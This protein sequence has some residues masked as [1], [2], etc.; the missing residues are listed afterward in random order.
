VAG[1]GAIGGLLFWMLSKYAGTA[2]FAAWKW[3]GQILALMFLGSMAGLFGV[4]LLTSSS[5]NSIRTYIFAIVCGVVWQP[6]IN[7]AMQSVVNATATKN[8]AEVSSQTAQLKITADHGSVQDVTLS[9]NATVPAV[10]QAIQQLPDVQDAAKKQEIVDSSQNAIGA[11][12][13]AAN[14]APDSSIDGIRQVGVAAGQG[15]HTSVSLRAVQSLRTIGL[16]ATSNNR[17]EVEKLTVESLKAISDH[18]SD[19]TVKSAVAATL[20]DLATAGTKPIDQPP[21][22][23]VPPR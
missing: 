15:N 1:A 19:P 12:E 23:S 20:S 3:Y 8:V 2:T 18:T 14:K 6:I 17:P 21:R 7:S 10:T 13:T 16:S 11:L 5:L 22:H 9:V 4:Y